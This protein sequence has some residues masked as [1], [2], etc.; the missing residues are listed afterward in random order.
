MAKQ[1][2]SYREAVRQ[3]LLEEMERDERVFIMGEEVGLYKGAYKVTE[4]LY[5]KFGEKRVIDS[6]ISEAGFVG[7]GIGAAHV[8][9][10]PVIEVM[11][12]NFAI[13]ALDQ[14]VN[15]AA[16]L[17]YMSGGQL[18]F[19]IVVRGP[20]GA[21]GAL[22]ASHSQSLDSYFVHCPGLKVVVPSTPQDA[23]SL[24]K[25]SI[26]DQD[27]VIFMEAEKLYNYK[28]EVEFGEHMVFPL[29]VG[30][31][32]HQG[33]DCTIVTYGRMY[34]HAVKPAVEKLAAEGIHVDV[35]DPRTV[36][37]LDLDM[38]LDSIRRTN[39]MVLV[40][41]NWPQASTGAW[42]CEQVYQH[43]FDHLDAPIGRV[44]QADGNLAYAS[45]LEEAALPSADK[46]VEAV[47][48]VMYAQV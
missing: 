38:I 20:H 13:L 8:D 7:L 36:R 6:P 47:K 41:E 32:K 42:I 43:G 22:G 35:V 14:I 46:V 24:L 44:T 5:E 3:A 48:K 17:R 27:P 37:P 40:E 23:Y 39:R 15:H 30:D 10:R 19:P 1:V 25:A 16:K 21:G 33:D 34:T 2:I 11:T 9:L 31:L 45:N 29:G 4:T 12:F 26:R 18:R 28:D